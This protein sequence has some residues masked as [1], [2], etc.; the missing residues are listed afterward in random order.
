T[1]QTIN[2]SFHTVT[3][4]IT[5]A[6]VQSGKFA[7]HTIGSSATLVGHAAGSSASFIG[8]ATVNTA[9]F[10][11]DIPKAG[12]L[13]RPADADKTPTPVIDTATPIDNKS[14]APATVNT[15]LTTPQP[16]SETQWPMHGA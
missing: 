4:S 16:D 1:E 9:G 13:I 12:A 2:N 11:A 14:T 3:N 6:T 5:V 10:I 15:K 8:H 7:A